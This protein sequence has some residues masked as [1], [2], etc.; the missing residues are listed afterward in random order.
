[1]NGY[2]FPAVL[3]AVPRLPT[4]RQWDAR[5]PDFVG[6]RRRPFQLIRQGLAEYES[7]RREYATCS[8]SYLQRREEMQQYENRQTQPD[9]AQ[10]RDS[11]PNA[12]RAA[13]ADGLAGYGP[14]LA[15]LLA[16]V[17]ECHRRVRQAFDGVCAA[18][19][20]LEWLDSNSGGGGARALSDLQAC[21]AA[22]RPIE[23][24]L[25]RSAKGY[26][27]DG[28]TAPEPQQRFDSSDETTL[29]SN[30]SG[31]TALPAETPARSGH[32]R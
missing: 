13:A 12:T 5:A 15:R 31:R 18:Y 4:A 9:R 20:E 32:R 27:S 26:H 3:P 28:S 21:L 1:M 2:E 29:T 14:D 23:E 24:A 6:P 30:D 16:A 11:S 7:C 19:D 17:V 8:R 22:G 25:D 10:R